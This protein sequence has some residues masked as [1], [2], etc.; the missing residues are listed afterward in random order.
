MILH[1][2]WAYLAQGA[3][4]AEHPGP[5]VTAAGSWDVE[6]LADVSAHLGCVF[7]TNQERQDDHEDNEGLVAPRVL[8]RCSRD[9]TSISKPSSLLV[10]P[11]WPPHLKL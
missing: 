7:D 8:A 9:R 3:C 4:A 6:A 1:V 5:E 10:H 2:K 11:A